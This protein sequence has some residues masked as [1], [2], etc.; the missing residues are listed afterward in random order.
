MVFCLFITRN[1]SVS[2]CP[3]DKSDLPSQED[4]E[5]EANPE[6]YVMNI[7]FKKDSIKWVT[8]MG[9]ALLQWSKV[10]FSDEYRLIFPAPE[11]WSLPGIVK[12]GKVSPTGT[13]I[14]KYHEVFG[15]AVLFKTDYSD[16]SKDDFE[17]I[18]IKS[19]LPSPVKDI[20]ENV[21]TTVTEGVDS[22]LSP[23]E[24]R[25]QV[26]KNYIE[27]M[28]DKNHVISLEMAHL[29]LNPMIEHQYVR[30]G[31]HFYNSFPAYPLS[32]DMKKNSIMVRFETGSV[33]GYSEDYIYMKPGE[34]PPVKPENFTNQVEK[35][36]GIMKKAGLK[37]TVPIVEEYVPKELTEHEQLLLK[38]KKIK[39]KNR[40]DRFNEEMKEKAK[41]R[42]NMKTYKSFKP[43]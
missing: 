39:E 29:L 9:T 34:F 15:P 10:Y 18:L 38:I 20:I 6:P 14:C 16:I 43:E 32:N 2:E 1:G 27:T 7:M 4:I 11:E 28:C 33:T 21:A 42:K 30:N 12:L 35:M 8:L 23:E 36:T 40:H 25:R 19:R 13:F 26:R 17:E 41:E 22:S 24:Y 5:N 3:F 31:E 37:Y